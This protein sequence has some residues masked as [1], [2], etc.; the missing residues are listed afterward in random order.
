MQPAACTMKYAVPVFM[1]VYIVV[2]AWRAWEHHQYYGLAFYFCCWWWHEKLSRGHATSRLVSACGGHLI[3]DTLI[4]DVRTM[5]Y[6]PFWSRPA[7]PGEC[8]LAGLCSKHTGK[9][10]RR[11][12]NWETRGRTSRSVYVTIPAWISRDG[13]CIS[14]TVK[15]W[16][17]N[18]RDYKIKETIC[19]GRG[20]NID[21][22][23][24]S[25]LLFY[26]I[27]ACFLA[28][29]VDWNWNCRI[30]HAWNYELIK[31]A[32]IPRLC[33]LMEQHR[34]W[35]VNRSVNLGVPACTSYVYYLQLLRSVY[36][37]LAWSV[38]YVV[39]TDRLM[40]ICNG[41][42]WRTTWAPSQCSDWV[43]VR[44][45]PAVCGYMMFSHWEGSKPLR[46]PRVDRESHCICGVFRFRKY[47]ASQVW[48]RYQPSYFVLS[49]SWLF[50]AR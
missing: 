4:G 30:V 7:A 42:R 45:I 14:S 31:L 11:P 43:E 39:C 33:E 17:R 32:F 18:Q 2:V 44:N 5:A 15:V 38:L 40:D 6:K 19:W 28:G 20:W 27:A 48:S 41:E 36:S 12:G 25:H 49:P 29:A 26:I 3:I 22:L 13:T 9:S 24:A 34:H 23:T 50:L 1:F 47:N 46:T 35:C 21:V 16:S 10:H 37:H 8:A